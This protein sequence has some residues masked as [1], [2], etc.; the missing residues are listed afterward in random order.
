[1]FES[2]FPSR[3]V[4]CV[5]SAQSRSIIEPAMV[6]FRRVYVENASEA[7]RT[8][9]AAVFDAYVIDYWVP[10]WTG[11]QLCRHIREIDLN[12]PIVVYNAGNQV[13]QR[14]RAIGAGANAFFVR[15]LNAEALRG[16]LTFLLDGRDEDSI[17][18]RLV[19]QAA[20]QT[21]LLH[22]TD[23]IKIRVEGAAKMAAQA[24]ERIAKAKAYKA[25]IE[26]GG[27]RSH[28]DE[29]WPQLYSQEILSTGA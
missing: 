11:V 27:L 12:A 10:E 3:P 19:E 26:A 17:R 8:A 14:S 20:V 29:W 18:A 9:N 13:G 22:Q 16:S 24:N 5:T 6:G 2:S 23:L 15:P 1:M 25:F 21:E 7:I 4:L 28:F